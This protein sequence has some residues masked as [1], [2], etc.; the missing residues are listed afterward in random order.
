MSDNEAIDFWAGMDKLAAGF[1]VAESGCGALTLAGKRC[2]AGRSRFA[3]LTCGRH[4][5]QGMQVLV[6]SKDG[7]S[8]HSPDFVCYICGD[9]ADSH[10]DPSEYVDCLTCTASMSLQCVKHQLQLDQIPEDTEVQ[11]MWCNRY[12]PEL[13]ILMTDSTHEG[14]ASLPPLAVVR[15]TD[16]RREPRQLFEAPAG[17]SSQANTFVEAMQ[18]RRLGQPR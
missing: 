12:R 4:K 2:Q 13:G 16:H 8:A 15:P 5:S 11:C 10:P 7:Q 3:S 9:D 18:D 6:R 14:V 1:Q 17:T